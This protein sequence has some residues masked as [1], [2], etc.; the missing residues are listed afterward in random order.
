MNT[1]SVSGIFV[2]TT[3]VLIGNQNKNLILKVAIDLF[4]QKGYNAVSIRDITREVGIKESSLYNHFKS[5]AFIL[6]TIYYN[7]RME[8]AKIIPPQDRL[9]DITAAMNIELFLTQGFQNFLEHIQNPETEK[10]W[11]IIYLEQVRD[12]VARA[13]YLNNIVA[14]ITD[15]MTVVFEKYIAL[16]QVKPY[17]PRMLSIQYQYP[18][19]QMVNSFI[20]SRIDGQETAGVEQMMVKHIHFFLSMFRKDIE[21]G[22]LLNV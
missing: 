3:G 7:F 19:L 8:I 9:D 12:D 2:D 10:I 4:S 11:R 6:E 1:V 17:D 13:I 21:E 22:G 16:G 18:L 15:S 20:L 5:K 14:G